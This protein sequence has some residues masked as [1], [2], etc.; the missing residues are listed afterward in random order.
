VA[1]DPEGTV[2]LERW[3]SEKDYRL[4]GREPPTEPGGLTVGVLCNRYLAARDLDVASGELSRSAFECYTRTARRLIA[5]FGR[6]LQVE[7]LGPENFRTLR[8]E[9][10][11]EYAPT[12]LTAEIAR[13]KAIFR[14]A[15]EDELVDRVTFGRAFKA[16]PKRVLLVARNVAPPKMLEPAELR[17]V[18]DEAPPVCRAYVLLGVNAAYGPHDVATLPRDAL[19]L[20]GAWVSHARRKTGVARRCPLWPETVDA[21]RETF[22]LQPKPRAAEYAHLAFISPMGRACHN[23]KRNTTIGMWFRTHL[24]DLGLYRPRLGFYVLR[25]IF[26]T[27]ADETHDWPAVNLIMGHTDPTMGGVYRQRISDDRLKAVVE[28]V[29]RWVFGQARKKP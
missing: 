20:D 8:A 14:W 3:L 26:R 24:E 9:L 19:D 16:P 1:D 12:T 6:H 18:I 11:R 2:A 21:I 28:H 25:R 10:A 7:D 13:V 17:R 5:T 23:D 22:R 27:V 4:A 29:R 15:V